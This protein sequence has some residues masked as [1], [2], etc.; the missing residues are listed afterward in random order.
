MASLSFDK[1]GT[2]RLLF[3]DQTGKRRTIRLGKIDRH[4]ARSFKAHAERL[5]ASQQL[6]TPIDSQT[7]AWLRSLSDQFHER[8]E[9]VGLVEPRER[10][11]TPTLGHV[12]DAYFK[13]ADVKPATI[14]RMKQARRHLEEHFGERFDLRDLTL[15]K[16]DEWRAVLVEAGY[17]E[18]TISRTVRYAR[19]FATW[20]MKRGLIDSNPFADLHAGSQS[21]QDRTVFV[22]RATI[23]RVIDEAP[24]AEWRLLIALSRYCG[25]RV[26]SEA[27][28]LRWADVDWDQSRLRVRS[29]KTEQHTGKG[30]RV[31]P[32]FPE[33]RAALMDVF[34]QAEEGSERVLASFRPGY[35]PHTEFRRI[36]ERA[37]V[38][39][40]PRT[41]HN[42]RAS[43]QIEL[44]AQYPLHTACAWL[45]NTQAIAAGHYLKVT[46][47][48]WQRAVGGAESG[49]LAAQKTA[50]HSTAHERTDSQESSEVFAGCDVA[51]SDAPKCESVQ[52]GQVGRGGLEPPTPAFS[53]PC[54]TN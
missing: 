15:S 30:A 14:T 54:S 53:M 29:P 2:I 21:N 13:A 31:V 16:A 47:P 38:E 3:N 19:S 35:N 7:I 52:N 22:E 20:A 51:P 12:L 49:A 50:Q 18:A 6:G 41:W 8:L 46:D 45:G 44:C 33:V 40:W 37:G 27:F 28:A 42:L 43:R 25:L 10:S 11:E 39:P 36:I 34:E 17:A 9:R 4:Y 26:P 5:I 48:D 1:T 23:E 24:S 32:I